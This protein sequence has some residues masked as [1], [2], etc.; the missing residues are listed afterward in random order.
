M[1][2]EPNIIFIQLRV[3]IEAINIKGIDSW[4]IFRSTPEQDSQREENTMLMIKSQ[5]MLISNLTSEKNELQAK[6]RIQ[7]NE[8]MTF[9]LTG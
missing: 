8:S 1:H 5:N 4:K 7:I 2:P 3:R 6:L 9:T